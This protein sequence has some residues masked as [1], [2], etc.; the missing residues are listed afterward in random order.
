MATSLLEQVVAG[1]APDVHRL[2]V[3]QYHLMRDC[4]VLHDGD[5]LELIDG[6]IVYKNRS[7]QGDATMVHGKRH[8][9]V[10]RQL[11]RLSARI[12]L[13]GLSLQTQ[14]PVAISSS[15]E[16]EPDATVMLGPV[17]DYRDR[18]PTPQ[19]AL[20]VIEVADSSLVFDRQT[21][22]RVYATAQ[23][24]NYWIVNLHDNTIEVY[25]QPNSTAGEYQSRRDYA[26][27]EIIVTELAPGKQ[28]TVAVNE[29]LP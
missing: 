28:L 1:Q 9:F 26:T 21:K 25:A 24:P 6:L 2:T 19:D 10:V 7:E 13:L 27:G 5:P 29:L 12:E 22:Q 11:Q 14:L 4:G 23:I 15:H 20:L 18:L 3:E 17:E 8:V 16:P